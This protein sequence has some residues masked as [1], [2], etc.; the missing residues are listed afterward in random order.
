MEV[1]IVS[2]SV[3]SEHLHKHPLNN[4]EDMAATFIYNDI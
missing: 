3:L 4:N 1:I 2:A